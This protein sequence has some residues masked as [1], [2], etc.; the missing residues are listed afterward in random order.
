MADA[1]SIGKAGPESVDKNFP[2]CVPPDGDES[3]S[4]G[5]GG[6]TPARILYAKGRET[7]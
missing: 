5:V 6:V 1:G 3:L 7:R 4:L 2:G